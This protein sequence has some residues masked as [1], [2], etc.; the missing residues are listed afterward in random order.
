MFSVFD[1]LR[2]NSLT[3]SDLLLFCSLGVTYWFSLKYISLY[4]S[5]M[6]DIK[7]SRSLHMRKDAVF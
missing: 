7:N 6:N 2:N 5:Q 3:L 4:Y 1:L